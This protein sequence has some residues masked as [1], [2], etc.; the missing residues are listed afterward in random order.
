MNEIE[1]KLVDQGVMAKMFGLSFDEMEGILTTH[2]LKDGIELGIQKALDERVRQSTA[3]AKI[4]MCS[5]INI[6]MEVI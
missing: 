4:R 3:N 5:L 2:G 6:K 1:K